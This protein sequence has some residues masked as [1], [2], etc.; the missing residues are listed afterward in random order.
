MKLLVVAFAVAG[1]SFCNN[2]KADCFMRVSTRLTSQPVNSSPTDMQ[3]LVTPDARGQKCVMRYRIHVGNDW[4]TVEGI[5]RGPTESVACSQALEPESGAFLEEVAP[6]RVGADTQMV[7]SDL[8]DIRVH[9]VRIGDVIWESETDLHTYPQERKYF[10]YKRT[11]CRMFVE[12]DAKNQNLMLY[13][14]IICRLNAN[15][16]SKWQV[17]DKY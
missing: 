6:Q 17:I 12:R 14:G 10:W 2:S 7:C 13:Q 8:P 11:Q 15:G 5:G 1:L 16:K 9:P 4:R 3:R